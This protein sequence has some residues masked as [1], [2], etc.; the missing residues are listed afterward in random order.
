MF[1]LHVDTAKTWRGGQNQTLLTVLGLRALGYRAALVAHPNGELTRRAAE[2]PDL[3]PIAT[4]GEMDLRAAWKLSRVLRMF[5]PSIVHAQDAHAVAMVALARPLARLDPSPRFVVSRRVDFHIRQN[6]FSRWKYS[7]VELFLCAST[8]IQHML[9]GDGVPAERTTV[10]HDGVDLERVA[11]TPGLDVHR[12]LWLPTGAPLVGN[13]AALVPHKGHKFLVQAAARV[14]RQVPD[15]RFV[16]VGEG[17]LHAALRRQIRTSQLE[18]HVVLT[19][20]RPDALSL[21]KGFDLFAMSSVTEGMGSVLLDAMAIGQPIVATR[22]GGIPEV[23]SD[24]RTGVLVPPRDADALAVAI[25]RLLRNGAER[26]RLGATAQEHVQRTFRVEQ[27]VQ[28]THD[29]YVRLA[30]T[31]PVADTGRHAGAG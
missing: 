7:Q 14:V 24:G 30:D 18:R 9:I 5:R 6:A 22:A 8:A 27:M 16:I 4:G 17:E 29:A 12:E 19:G 10:V 15:A 25:T 1:S 21:Q 31:P 23:I 28:R 11:A 2:G 26:A 20:F 3:I 13:V